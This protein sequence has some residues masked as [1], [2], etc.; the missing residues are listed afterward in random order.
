MVFFAIVLESSQHRLAE[1]ESFPAEYA[2]GTYK[3]FY[4]GHA[5][6]LGK[7]SEILAM[8]FAIAPLNP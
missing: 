4:R 6:A 3:C 5:V 7:K 1:F 2:R 8:K